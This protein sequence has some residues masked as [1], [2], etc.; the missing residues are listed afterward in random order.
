M[1]T[2]PADRSKLAIAQQNQVAGKPAAAKANIDAM[3]EA[4]DTIDLLNQKVDD[5]LANPTI[6]DGSV[7]SP[8]LANAA[9]NTSKIANGAV[10]N[11]KIA[12][13][14]LTANKFVPGALTNETQNGLRIT[15]LEE[16]VTELKAD[17]AHALAAQLFQM[18]ISLGSV[19]Y[20]QFIPPV[21][22]A[23]LPCRFWRAADGKWYHD[24]DFDQFKGGTEIYCDSVS[25]NDTTGDGSD[26]LPYRTINKAM[27]VAIAGSDPAY[28]IRCKSL[29]F[30]RGMGPLQKTVEGKIIAIVPADPDERVIISNHYD[31]LSWSFVGSGTWKA[32][33]SDVRSVFDLRHK[34][35]YGVPIAFDSKS[36]LADCQANAYSWYTDNVD[37]WVHTGDGLAPDDTNWVINVSSPQFEV[38]LLD[39]A[40]MYLENV[41]V[42]HGRSISSMLILG[43]TTGS[44]VT[45]KFVS[46]NCAFAGGDLRHNRDSSVNAISFIDVKEVYNFNSYAAYGGEDGFNYHYANVP[47][48]NRRDCLAIEYYCGSYK[49]GKYSTT[50][51]SNATTAHDGSCILRI[52][53]FGFESR[54]PILTDVDGCFSICIDC[55]MRDSTTSFP[56]LKTAFQFRNDSGEGKAILINCGGGGVDTYACSVE[57]G[58]DITLQAFRG[59]NFPPGF[60]AK[61]V[62]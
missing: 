33:R 51:T 6:P 52:G 54:G 23:D 56:S 32:S 49:C 2:L 17:F 28:V 58:F 48:G 15:E 20:G 50:N 61:I 24:F 3:T 30:R 12:D 16:E 36:S 35:V 55:N 1:A 26:S 45:G 44:T 43:D 62:S 9:V 13:G 19:P 11:Q 34:D 42:L 10:T 38:T 8:K 41:T 31:N 29:H 27:Q 22:F 37:V 46:K 5:H 59:T 7:T 14:T 18:Y 39:D 60:E 53:S 57:E 40:V 25:G 4:Y 47:S 21:G